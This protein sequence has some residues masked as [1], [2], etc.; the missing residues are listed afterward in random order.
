[1]TSIAALIQAVHEAGGRLHPI[2]S[3]RLKVRA[4]HPLDEGL[5]SELREHKAAVL[6]FLAGQRPEAPPPPA[7]TAPAEW[8]AGV[9]RL[10]GMATPTGY[11]KGRWRLIA[12][13]AESVI[14]T[15]AGQAAALGWSTAEVFGCHRWAPAKRYDAAGLVPARGT[16]RHRPQPR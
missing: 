7:T 9:A 10:I 11:S 15:W 5:V 2:G 16:P 8:V 3:D 6:A 1:M 12:T 4:P 14:N 13:D